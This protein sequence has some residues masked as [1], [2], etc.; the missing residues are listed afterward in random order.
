ME[1][2]EQMEQE[3]GNTKTPSFKCRK[4]VFTLNNYLQEEVDKI[5]LFLEQKTL[6]FIFGYEVGENGTPHLQGYMEFKNPVHFD[7]LKKVNS[8]WHLEKAR[9]NVD[10]NFNYC[11]KDGNYEVKGIEPPYIENLKEEDLYDWEKEIID[12]CNKEPDKR[13]IY[14]F[15]EPTGCRGKTTFQKYLITHNEEGKVLMIDGCSSDM[16]NAIVQIKKNTGFLPKI[17][18]MNIPKDRKHISYSGIEAIKDMCFYSGKYEGGMICG[19]CPHFII[20][21][22]Y[23][24]DYKKMSAD[25]FVVKKI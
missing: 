15:W 8:R 12:I 4:Y 11:S 1:H 2:L 10:D 13:T 18:L 21:A 23:E 7:S 3:G 6:K 17:C 20:F 19:K 24:P 16:R 22:N 25:R 5:K 9:G 14:W